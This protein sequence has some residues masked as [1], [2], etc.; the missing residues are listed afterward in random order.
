VIDR[1]RSLANAIVEK[2]GKAR[3]RSPRARRIGLSIALVLFIGA[4]TLAIRHLPAIPK[5]DHREPLLFVPIAL[6]S[7]G[8]IFL[9]GLEYVLSARAIG[10]SVP[11]RESTRVSVLSTAANLLPIPGAAIVKTRALQNRGA[12]LGTAASLTIA[13][14]L[15]WVGVGCIG[16]GGLLAITTDRTLMAVL[17]LAGGALSMA[18][19]AVLFVGRSTAMSVPSVMGWA[20]LLEASSVTLTSVRFTLVLRAMGFHG[21][22]AQG[23]TLAATAIV[24]SAAGI[25]P[26]G[27]GLRELLSGIIGPAVG[28][29]AAVATVAAAVER[30]VSLCVLGVTALVII[31][32]D[33]G[34]IVNAPPTPEPTTKDASCA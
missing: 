33:R 30:I 24:A 13:I 14:G 20:T 12:R 23:A 2:M 25:F 16:A 21:T 9:N 29:S 3:M 27:L 26:G 17:L 28:L 32:I 19:S 18:L 8:T 4:T 31:V 22:F 34:E 1:L 7:F 5:A 10:H 15:V 11:L 6:L